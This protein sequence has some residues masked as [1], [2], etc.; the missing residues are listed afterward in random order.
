[1]TSLKRWT[2]KSV[3]NI[4]KKS[5]VKK[6]KKTSMA[7]PMDPA[8]QY[9]ISEPQIPTVSIR[10]STLNKVIHYLKVYIKFI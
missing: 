6:Y 8:V 1:M 10:R 9:L 4:Y 2:A 3:K 7:G 5:E